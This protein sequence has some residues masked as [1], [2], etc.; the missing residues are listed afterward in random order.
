MIGDGLIDEVLKLKQ[1]GFNQSSV[2]RHTVGYKE[3]LEYLDGHYQLDR[4]V[5]LIKQKTRNYAKRQLT[6]F[7]TNKDIIQVD[8]EHASW[9][10][11][12]TRIVDKFKLDT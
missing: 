11:E 5:E 3:V 9:R 12:L 2:L 10:K 6:W 8:L 1:L 4:C 7:R